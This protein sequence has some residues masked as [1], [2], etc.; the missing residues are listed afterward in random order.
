M[1]VALAVSGILLAGCTP[2]AMPVQPAPLTIPAN[3]SVHDATQRA[4]NSLVVDGFD[5]A[6]SDVNGGIVS[7]RRVRSDSG[8][9][10]F[11]T[12]F[13]KQRSMAGASLRSALTITLAV[14]PSDSGSVATVTSRVLAEYPTLTGMLA[15]QPNE[16][17]CASSGLAESHIAAALRSP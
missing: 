12:C 11:V 10:G 13:Y 8:N 9:A 6:T 2:P 4:A 14:K 3:R 1:R 5:I 15:R 17:D 16:T 7:A